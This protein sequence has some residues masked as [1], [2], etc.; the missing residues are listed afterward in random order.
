MKSGNVNPKRVNVEIDFKF[1]GLDRF[2]PVFQPFSKLKQFVFL[3]YIYIYVVFW[4]R[5]FVSWHS[6]VG[7][8]FNAKVTLLEEQ[9][10]YYV[11]H[12]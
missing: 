3:R 8:L 12:S 1:Q 4:L 10:W 2:H 7:G 6:N 11:T 5:F 9:Q